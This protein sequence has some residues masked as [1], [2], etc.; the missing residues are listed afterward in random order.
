MNTISCFFYLNS[1]LVTM[2]K[3]FEVSYLILLSFTVIWFLS[4]CTKSKSDM[5]SLIDKSKTLTQANGI[6]QLTLYDGT[7]WSWRMINNKMQWERTI[8]FPNWIK[9]VWAVINGKKEWQRAITSVDGTEEVWNYVDGKREWMRNVK[10]T[11]WIKYVWKYINDT[12]EWRRTITSDGVKVV[13][14]YVNGKMDWKWIMTFPM[15]KQQS[16]IIV[17]E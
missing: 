11:D 13:W 1:Y 5:W 15:V 17:M 6:T 9:Q 12:M 16:H 8:I 14:K 7:Y 2:Y 3:K 4:W 10:S